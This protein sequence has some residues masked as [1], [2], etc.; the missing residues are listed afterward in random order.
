MP[1]LRKARAKNIRG[2]AK[3]ATLVKHLESFKEFDLNGAKSLYAEALMLSGR[4]DNAAR[5]Y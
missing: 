1:L 5:V 2:T 4:Y 3:N